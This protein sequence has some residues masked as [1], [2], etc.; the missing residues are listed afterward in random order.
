MTWQPI[1]T[2]PKDGT[3][4]L[5]YS[6]MARV[7]YAHRERTYPDIAVVAFTD[8]WWSNTAFEHHRFPHP[9]H[10]MPLPEKPIDDPVC[11]FPDKKGGR[12]EY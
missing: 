6:R 11:E 7:L 4:I 10:W 8:D 9:T 2:A 3:R 12:Y 5:A 1:E